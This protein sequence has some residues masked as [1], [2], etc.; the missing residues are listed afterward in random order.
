MDKKTIDDVLA[1]L[2]DWINHGYSADVGIDSIRGKEISDSFEEY[3][4]FRNDE[5]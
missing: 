2:V 1:L 5:F 3:I 4:M